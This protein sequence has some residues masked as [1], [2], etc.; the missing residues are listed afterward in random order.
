MENKKYL[1][2]KYIDIEGNEKY[3]VAIYGRWFFIKGYWYF[4]DRLKCL[5]SLEKAK[6]AI[7]KREDCMNFKEY[8]SAQAILFYCL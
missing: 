6:E 5:D 8:V 2:T 1:I 7:K 3:S 4:D